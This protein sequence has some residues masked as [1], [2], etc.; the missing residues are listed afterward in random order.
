MHVVEIEIAYSKLLKGIVDGGF[1]LV[2]VMAIYDQHDN[3]LEQA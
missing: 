2:W 1:H 3:G